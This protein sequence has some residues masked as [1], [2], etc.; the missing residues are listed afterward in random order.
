MFGGFAG[1]SDVNGGGVEFAAEGVVFSELI[2][3]LG[4][5]D[6]VEGL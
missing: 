4:T 5:F 3:L 1:I 6:F 2:E